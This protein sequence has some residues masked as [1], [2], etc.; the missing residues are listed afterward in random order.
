MDPGN[1]AG[2]DIAGTLDE[3]DRGERRVVGRIAVEAR[4]VRAV[5]GMGDQSH[6]HTSRR[7]R[8]HYSQSRRRR[9][10]ARAIAPAVI[11]ASPQRRS[12]GVRPLRFITLDAP[13]GQDH[14]APLPIRARS[15][16]IRSRLG[17]GD[18][19]GLVPVEP[20]AHLADRLQR[21]RSSP[22][23]QGMAPPHAPVFP[24]RSGADGCRAGQERASRPS[25]RAVRHACL[26][27]LER[28]SWG[29]SA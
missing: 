7:W 25:K 28:L 8:H 22:S 17:G 13:R 5:R 19:R 4:L 24:R 10:S 1:A 3:A 16:G 11:A 9:E 27:L 23:L 26:P 6:E 29:L 20:R 12:A 14:L 18:V 15:G 21:R 2:I